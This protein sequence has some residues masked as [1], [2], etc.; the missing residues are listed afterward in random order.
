MIGILCALEAE[1]SKLYELIE[2]PVI[3]E[4]YGYRFAAGKLE[5][6]NVVVAKCGVGK[7]NAA[8]C[9]QTMILKY[10]PELIINSGVAGSLSGELSIC[11]IAIGTDVVQ[12]DFDTSAC[13]D[14]VGVITMV[15]GN[16]LSFPC[17]ATAANAIA[18]A[19]AHVGVHAIPARIASGDQF[20]SDGAKKRWIVDTF[21]AKACEMESGAIAQACYISGVKCAVIRAISDSTDGA[22]EME[23][24][25]FLKVA[26]DNSIKVL[27]ET[28]RR[29]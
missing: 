15:N 11:D 3:E 25:Q 8:V 29:L 21:D 20:I 28:L 14:P 5:G 2:E 9:A 17:D 27:L 23:F 18:D 19:A 22:H 1:V 13:G 16:V 24:T 10:A 12:H 7:V 4:V 26:A 6:K